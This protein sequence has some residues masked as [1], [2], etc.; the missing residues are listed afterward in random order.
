[1]QAYREPLFNKST[2][3]FISIQILP[4]EKKTMIH[5]SNSLTEILSINNFWQKFPS[6]YF[7]CFFIATFI[8]IFCNLSKQCESEIKNKAFARFE[9]ASII[10]ERLSYCDS[11]LLIKS[12]LRCLVVK[13]IFSQVS[14][15]QGP[16][17]SMI[18]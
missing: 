18:N 3:S 11:A 10:F 6:F 15:L 9:L 12:L 16:I 4:V 1:M 5:P 17:L 7:C 8:Y 13:K 2:L 14:T